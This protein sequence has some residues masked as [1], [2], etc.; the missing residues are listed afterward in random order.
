MA[1]PCTAAVAEDVAALLAQRVPAASAGS[2]I[3]D[4]EV[5]FWI[6]VEQAEA[7]LGAVRAE[8]ARMRDAGVPVQPE[9]VVARP[10]LP[11]QEWRDA[12]KRYFHTVRLTRQIL[13][14]PSWEERP[15]PAA[16]DLIIDLDPGQAFGTGAHASTR[17]VLEAEQALRDEGAAVARF[18]DVGTGSAILAIAAARLWPDSAGLAIDVDPLAVDVA[19][20]NCAINR[21]GARIQVAATPL[22]AVEG[23]F[24]LVLAN[25]QADVLALLRA[26]LIGRL[27]PGGALILSGLLAEQA[28]EVAREFAAAAGIELVA[29]L[30]S[31]DDPEWSAVRL[32]RRP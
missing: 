2:E 24:D 22:A 16:D 9:Q 19:A 21:V 26:D 10:A 5:V 8:T 13:V 23:Q 6:P 3:R 4:G 32:R 18:L 15:L 7:V 17:L 29:V 30:P 14:V 31:A 1:V 28:P 27:A 11:E 25:I 12:W 20:E